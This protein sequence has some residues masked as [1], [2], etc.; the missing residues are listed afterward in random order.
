MGDFDNNDSDD[1]TTDTT[2]ERSND[3]SSTSLSIYISDLQ[4]EKL[5]TSKE[6]QNI[7]RQYKEGDLLA[8]TTLIQK[9]LRL[10]VK[11]A[12][13]YMHR[14]VPLEDIIEEGNL[15]LMRAVDKFNPD[16]GFRLST[17]ATW[18]IRQSI[19]KA[20]M[21]QGRTVRLPV[22]VLKK[23][24]KCN[25]EKKKL[26]DSGI[27]HVSIKDLEEVVN[28]STDEIE[29]LLM[30]NEPSISIE[31]MD[32]NLESIFS[33]CNIDKDE[34]EH[35]IYENQL[36]KMLFHWIGKLPSSQ[37]HTINYYYGLHNTEPRT[38]VEIANILGTTREGVRKHQRQALRALKSLCYTSGMMDISK[39]LHH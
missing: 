22:H 31:D 10:V 16:Y 20:I 15:G 35:I 2:N 29:K 33:S 3:S 18:W 27:R 6:E 13:R 17:Y 39:N 8:R 7:A 32:N 1:V 38:L 24:S 11:I 37:Q 4:K 19:E 12:K 9:N 28:F 30:F 14:G 5:L 26:E 36:R 34:L 23:I 25:R 21:N